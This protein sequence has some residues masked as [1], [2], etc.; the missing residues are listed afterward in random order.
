MY[1]F[2]YISTA[3]LRPGEVKESMIKEKT[4]LSIS[5]L[6]HLIYNSDWPTL[7]SVK[8]N[9]KVKYNSVLLLQF[10]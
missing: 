10:N 7:H 9:R 3:D 5:L 8:S 1:I 4:C 2:I 6:K